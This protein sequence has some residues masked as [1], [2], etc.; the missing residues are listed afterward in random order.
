M[1]KVF[2]LYYNLWLPLTMSKDLCK[3]CLLHCLSFYLYLCCFSSLLLSN[4]HY[5][6]NIRHSFTQSH[7]EVIHL[8][9]LS[10]PIVMVPWL[11][12]SWAMTLL[13]DQLRQSAVRQWFFH[14][15]RCPSMQSSC[16]GKLQCGKLTVTMCLL[17]TCIPSLSFFFSH[18]LSILFFEVL[19]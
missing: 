9:M 8:F 4:T 17:F 11:Q 2:F 13:W 10:Q 14:T 12:T 3:T 7:S 6:I 5:W 19:W 1:Q 15:R 18:L 16:K